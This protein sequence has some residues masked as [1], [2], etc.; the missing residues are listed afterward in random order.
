MKLTAKITAKQASITATL[1]PAVIAQ[2]KLN[3]YE[4]AQ[5]HGFTGSFDEFL[6]SLKIDD[7]QELISTDDGNQL[8]TGADGLLYTNQS[9]KRLDIDF[10]NLIDTAL[11]TGL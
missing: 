2:A 8:T 11:H 7:P 4:L 6:A 10:V 9:D 1:D 3:L 5:K